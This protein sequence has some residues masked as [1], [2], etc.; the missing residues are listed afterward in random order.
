MRKKVLAMILAVVSCVSMVACGS[1][2]KQTVA[3]EET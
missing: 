1:T 3:S 2:E